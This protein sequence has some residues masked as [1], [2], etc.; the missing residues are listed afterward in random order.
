ML[1]RATYFIPLLIG[2]AIAAVITAGYFADEEG[3]IQKTRLQ[4]F[5]KLST[6]QSGVENALNTKLHLA[7]ALKS[8][9]ELNPNIGQKEFVVLA[10]R[11]TADVSGIRFL[12]L[13]RNNIVTHIFP[14]NGPNQALGRNLLKDYPANIRDMTLRA[15][16]TRQ[17]QITTPKTTIEGGD[18]IIAATP[19]YLN[20]GKKDGASRYWGLVL[21]LIDTKTL[22]R[23]AGL[24]N[25]SPGL[26]LAMRKPEMNIANDNLLIG[27]QSVFDRNPVILNIPIP[28]G[29]WQVAAT[30]LG[31]WPDSPNKPY[32]IGGGILGTIV[33]MASLWAALFMIHDRLDEREKYRYL[34]QN[35][36]SIILRIDMSGN[37]TFCN[38]HAEEFYGYESG[39]LI[40]QPLIGTL[41]PEKNLEGE[42]MKRYINRLIRNPAAHPF[43]ET[44]N[45]RKN[46]EFVWVAWANQPVLGRNGHMVELLSVGTDITDRKLMEEALRQS[47][48]Q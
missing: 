24:I 26:E 32:I 29:Y 25:A 37:I 5:Y 8:F 48:K 16:E 33:I 41:T 1:K 6:I 17:S 39:E 3:H 31:G 11:L 45:V 28:A 13:A 43:N 30:P 46:G 15:R 34:V 7:N 35:A 27:K 9:I 38:E 23:E 10:K 44:I 36:K 19:V 18:A 47:E 40:G 12:E 4:V 14:N 21:V 20:D 42:S 22:Y 2:L